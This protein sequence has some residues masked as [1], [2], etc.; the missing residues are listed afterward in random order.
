[1]PAKLAA[2]V[3]RMMAKAPEDR[4]Q[5]PAEAAKALAPFAG[6]AP[7]SRPR[8]FWGLAAA[9]LLMLAAGLGIVAFMAGRRQPTGPAEPAGEVVVQSPEKAGM[10]AFL[11]D[12]QR[13]RV[14]D[15][16]QELSCKLDPGD[17]DLEL[18]NGPDDLYLPVERCQVAEGVPTTIQI[19]RVEV[20]QE[21]SDPIGNFGWAAFTPDGRRVLSGGN[22]NPL[23]M[24]DVATGTQL[25]VFDCPGPKFVYGIAV[26]PDGRSV[27]WGAGSIVRLSDLDSGNEIGTFGGHNGPLL[28][29]AFSPDGTRLL[30]GAED[31]TMRLWDVKTRK[32]LDQFFL[33]AAVRSVG[34]TPDGLHALGSRFVR[35]NNLVPLQL[36]NLHDRM[37]EHRLDDSRGTFRNVAVVSADGRRVLAGG[38]EKM[39]LWDLETGKELQRFTGHKGFVRSVAFLPDGRHVLSGSWDGTARVWDVAS[40]RQLY[41]FTKHQGMLK[42][43]A[44]APD[45][46]HALTA[47]E[48]KVMRL[49]RMPVPDPVPRTPETGGELVVETPENAG[50]LVIEQGGKRVRVL[51]LQKERSCKLDA[52]DYDLA[53][54]LAPDDLFLTAARCHVGPGAKATIRLDQGKVVKVYQGLTQPGGGVCVAVT[55]DGRGVLSGGHNNPL[56]LWDVATGKLRVFDCPGSKDVFGIAVSPDGRSVAWGAGPIVRLSD[57]KTGAEIGTFA[58]H[59]KTVASVAFSPNGATLLSVGSG[60]IMRFWKV[61]GRKLL[62]GFPLGKGLT[63]ADGLHT[64]LSMDGT[65][66]EQALAQLRDLQARRNEPGQG[67]SRGT[68]DEEGV[69]S[70]DGRLVLSARDKSLLL[71]EYQTGKELLRITPHKDTGARN[72]AI[73]PDGR[74]LLSVSYDGTAKIWDAGSGRLLYTFTRHRGQVKGIALDPDGRHVFTVASDGLVIRWRL[75]MPDPAP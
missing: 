37:E 1:M 65:N 44:V 5:T 26:A 13:V 40:G 29:V 52:G 60:G 41:C 9:A 49:W 56:R 64:L 16:Q 47:G 36:W 73:L 63:K 8:W 19:R 18:T 34:F 6:V 58:G 22:D 28:S 17:Y 74:R 20:V 27:A 72:I 24:W 21:F 70:P 51:D 50:L 10:L 43:V 11:Q 3:A 2:V 38:D 33:D 12:G 23:R 59:T 30:S 14:L 48:D 45:G 7:P 42:A 25:R 69:V 4:Y 57:L 61:Q 54:T 32:Q 75:P 68:K 15:L 71:W 39:T 62:G 53:L 31:G 35:R 66:N 46:C 55:P 67:P